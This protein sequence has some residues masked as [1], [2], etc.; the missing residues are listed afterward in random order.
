MTSAPGAGLMRASPL[1]GA[2]IMTRAIALAV[3]AL[4]FAACG[5]SLCT[6]SDDE[7][8]RILAGQAK[9][10]YTANSVTISITPSSSTSTCEANVSKCTSADQKIVDEWLT[11]LKGVPA[12]AAGSEKTTVDGYLACAVKLFDTSTQTSKLS[13][14]CAAS[15]Q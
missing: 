10:E 13:A 7:Q 14:D 4:T 3:A 5:G 12:C 11:C 2:T 15:F 8:K 1:T 9:C 6:R